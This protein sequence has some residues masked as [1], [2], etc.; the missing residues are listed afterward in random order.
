MMNLEDVKT[1]F[2]GLPWKWQEPQPRGPERYA[3]P[4]LAVCDIAGG[5]CAARGDREDFYS[6]DVVGP[7]Y[8][9]FFYAET[10]DDLVVKTR[11][12]LGAYVKR[13]GSAVNVRFVRRVLGGA[14]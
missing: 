2:H 9:W 8:R 10:L 3:T 14:G 11:A 4:G 1:A 13:G 7:T 12:K 5:W 6:I